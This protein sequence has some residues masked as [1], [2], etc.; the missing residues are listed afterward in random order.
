MMPADSFDGEGRVSVAN[1]PWMSRAIAW[2]CSLVA[3]N[4]NGKV[5]PIPV[6][7]LGGQVWPFI[8]R[9][10]CL[11][12]LR[13]EGCQELVG[14]RPPPVRIKPQQVAVAGNTVE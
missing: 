12:D 11:G 6:I 8:G 5:A 10:H 14:D 1:P 9:D 2:P 3:A 13:M 4:G 7:R